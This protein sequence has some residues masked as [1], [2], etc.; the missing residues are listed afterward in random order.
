MPLT[1]NDKKFMRN[2]KEEYGPKK[3]ERIFYAIENKRKR[4]R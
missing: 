4:K 3:G 1:K 2:L